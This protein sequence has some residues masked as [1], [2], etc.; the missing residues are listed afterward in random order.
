MNGMDGNGQNMNMNMNSKLN[1]RDSINNRTMNGIGGTAS[2]NTKS[3]ESQEE[4]TETQADTKELIEKL[5]NDL[6]T[7]VKKILNVFSTDS[8][9][10]PIIK[11]KQ[12][13]EVKGLISA[14]KN[15]QGING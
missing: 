10:K 5:N 14:A 3:I 12:M 8:Q 11:S 13:K 9:I 6:V 1:N 7:S 15:A 2:T 4:V